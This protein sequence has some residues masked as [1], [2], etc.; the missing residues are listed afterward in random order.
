METKGSV[1]QRRR[2]AVMNRVSEGEEIINSAAPGYL[3]DKERCTEL[4]CFE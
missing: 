1:Q 3:F 2:E 4:N